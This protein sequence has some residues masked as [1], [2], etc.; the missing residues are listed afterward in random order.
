M[1]A[2]VSHSI[3]NFYFDLSKSSGATSLPAPMVVNAT[4]RFL[5]ENFQKYNSSKSD[6]GGFSIKEG[7]LVHG[8]AAL[9]GTLCMGVVCIGAKH[10]T[11]YLNQ[12]LGADPVL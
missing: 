5:Q 8:E 11:R 6:F 3:V 10:R 9:V 7:E 2:V 4:A 1:D 12:A